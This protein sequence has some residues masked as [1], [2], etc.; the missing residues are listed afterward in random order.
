MHAAAVAFADGAAVHG[1]Q[2]DL[3]TLED[4]EEFGKHAGIIEA[5]AGFYRERN[6][7]GLAQ[8]AG[9]KT[10]I[11][12][13]DIPPGKHVFRCDMEEINKPARFMRRDK[14]VNDRRVSQKARQHPRKGRFRGTTHSV[15]LCLCGGFCAFI[16][17]DS[18][19]PELG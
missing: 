13:S 14:G 8:R 11:K 16:N 17:N 18:R 5:N 2:I 15:D 6:L 3:M 1:E 4:R 12:R 9:N 7:H 10:K 19:R